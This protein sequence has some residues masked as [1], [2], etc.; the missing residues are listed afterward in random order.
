MN[1]H[2]GRKL[3][4]RSSFKIDSNVL[5]YFDSWIEI[6]IPKPWNIEME[7]LNYHDFCISSYRAFPEFEGC[8]TI[9]LF[10]SSSESLNSKFV[11]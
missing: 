5:S 11:I 2:L 7:C 6:D 4:T 9:K 10:D 1:I 3:L 8:Y